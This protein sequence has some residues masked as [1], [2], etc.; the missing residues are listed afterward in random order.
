PVVTPPVVT[1]PVA[2][3]LPPGAATPPPV[4]PPV[5]IATPVLAAP[6][7]PGLSGGPQLAVVGGGVR[8]PAIE[9]A[10]NDVPEEEETAPVVRPAPIQTPVKP[11][12]P[13][14]PRKQARH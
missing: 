5:L 8:M 14:Y 4:V 6:L 13:I 7:L 1:P 11:A 12:V 10:R 9:I 3:P 2:T